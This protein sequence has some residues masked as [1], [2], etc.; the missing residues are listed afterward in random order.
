MQSISAFVRFKENLRDPQ[1][2]KDKPSN[3]ITFQKRN[4]ITVVYEMCVLLPGPLTAKR[5]L[6]LSSQYLRCQTAKKV[7]L[8]FPK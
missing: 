1:L 4:V 2:I 7:S 3:V 6:R 8:L 5:R